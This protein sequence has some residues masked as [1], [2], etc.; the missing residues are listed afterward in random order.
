MLWA[1][2]AR[3]ADTASLARPQVGGW[4]LAACRPAYF[5]QNGGL[6][7]SPFVACSQRQTTQTTQREQRNSGANAIGGF[8]RSP[9]KV[10]GT[11]LIYPDASRAF[12]AAHS[13]VGC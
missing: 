4:L 13:A 11:M 7:N 10:F 1:R 12:G 9:L 5:A 2:P 6:V 3:T 8:A